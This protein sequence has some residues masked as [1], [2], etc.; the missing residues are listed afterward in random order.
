MF[1]SVVAPRA[2]CRPREVSRQ[3]V[4][5]GEHLSRPLRLSSLDLEI[6]S[7]RHLKSSRLIAE[8]GVL[9]SV[10]QLAREI[11]QFAFDSKVFCSR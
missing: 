2:R 5:L 3:V 9:I 8:F 4:F 6:L 10:F 7:A 1:I 11:T